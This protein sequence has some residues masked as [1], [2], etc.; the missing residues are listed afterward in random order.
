MNSS[1]RCSGW[2]LLFIAFNV[3]HTFILSLLSRLLYL[4][5]VAT[6]VIEAGY[7][8]TLHHFR[9]LHCELHT[10]L[11]QSFMLCANIRNPKLVA[12]IPCSKIA[13][14]YVFAAGL[15]FGSSTSSV[16]FWSSGETTVSHL[17]CPAGTSFSSQSPGFQYKTSG[18]ILIVNEYAGV[19]DFH[20]IL[21]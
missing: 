2:Q 18:F 10:E 14:W 17:Y 12:G 9:W 20:Q 11:L 3:V 5:Q 16:P 15:S 21:H 6:G 13:F 1:S 4:Y 19:Y 7:D 8:H